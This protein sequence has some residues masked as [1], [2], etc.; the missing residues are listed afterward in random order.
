MEEEYEEKRKHPR[1]TIDLGYRFLQP[2][3]DPLWNR[4]SISKSGMFLQTDAPC[5]IGDEIPIELRLPGVDEVLILTGRVVRVVKPGEG[6]PCGMGVEFVNLSSRAR[7]LLDKCLEGFVREYMTILLVTEDLHLGKMAQL[8]LQ[9]QGHR[10][11]WIKGWREIPGIIKKE[12]VDL[13]ACDIGT[14]ELDPG[15][16]KT[17]S[18]GL[19]LVIMCDEIS[20]KV[21]QKAVELGIYE[22]L[23]KPLEPEEFENAVENAYERAKAVGGTQAQAANLVFEDIPLI[24]RSPCM[25]ELSILILKHAKT[26]LPL[27][28]T[29][30]T[31][32]GK[33]MIVSLLHSLSPRANR[34]LV[35]VDCTQFSAWNKDRMISELFGHEAG[36]F[37]GAKRKHI[38]LVE[39]A[40][41][42]TL[43]LDEIGDLPTDCQRQLYRV[44]DEGKYRRLG[45]N[46]DLKCDVRIVAASSSDLRE[47]AIKGEF[48]KPLYYRLRFHRIEVPPLRERKE[49]IE[50][51]VL[52]YMERKRKKGETSVKYLGQKARKQLMEHSWDGN[53][54]DLWSVVENSLAEV[55]AEGDTLPF[56]KIEPAIL[57]DTKPK[58]R[59]PDFDLPW[60]TCRKKKVNEV[61]RD[62]ILDCLS[63]AN[64]EVAQAAEL[65]GI[66]IQKFYEK[67]KRHGIQ[68][69]DVKKKKV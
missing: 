30:E 60:S 34:P 37:T 5:D 24:V 26:L 19:P 8:L 69:S 56:V 33:G 66:S 54:R 2:S 38:G 12:K 29:G 6:D 23:T 68:R 27:L 47:M 42:G 9:E 11:M 31:G 10:V 48:E 63:R 14:T 43:F 28:V 53:V 4:L 55:E 59:D 16:L 65:A 36:A 21:Q 52:K 25:R 58:S 57:A 41:G 7:S 45:G 13:V 50:P 1:A 40:D 49:D 62:Y 20:P 39:K 18:A 67:M 15:I 35:V 32:V 46:K 22:V 44:V 61:E 64:G 51:L 17:S 3:V